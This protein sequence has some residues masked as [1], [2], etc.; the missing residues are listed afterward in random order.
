MTGNLL[1][2][3]PGLMT[4]VQDLGR[5]GYQR[6]GI[7]VSGA[8]D[9][10]AL[11]A[12]NVVVGNPQETACLEMAV[13][14]PVLEVHAPAVRIALA[15][16]GAELAVETP[17]GE[18]LQVPALQSV[19]L[20]EGDRLKISRMGAS[21]V[22]YLSIEGGLDLPRFMGSLSTYPRGGF[23]GYEGRALAA[24]DQLP[25][26][27]AEAPKRPEQ[28]LGGFDLGPAQGVRVVLGP[29]DDYFSPEAIAAFLAG[30]YTVSRDADRM[31]VRLEG[32]PVAHAKG[33]NIVS[34]GIAPG[35]IQVPGSRQP[36]VLL[37][38]R[39]TTGG[40]PKI[41]TVISADLPALG[42]VRP[43]MAIRFEAIGVAA[44]QELRR[45]FE[46]RM[47]GLATELEVVRGEG[48]D[49]ERLYDA[50]LISGV[51][52]GHGEGDAHGAP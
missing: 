11:R 37:S 16:E 36:I 32:P 15:G 14:G 27:L 20:V 12:A 35:S 39:Q 44:A 47:A 24:G 33:Y 38:D 25:L 23:G 3:Q 4:T 34:D 45:A 9:T 42:R 5:R 10:T 17:A 41:A 46:A 30:T 48:V 21:A 50:N 49:V 18:I 40:Y 1:V 43:G 51:T 2:V 13:M 6:L 22:A 7:P 29:Q 52:S 28:R 26:R 8:L 19:R 31:G